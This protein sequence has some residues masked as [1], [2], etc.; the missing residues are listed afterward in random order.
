MGEI[1][2]KEVL[3]LEGKQRD[4]QKKLYSNLPIIVYLLFPIFDVKLERLYHKNYI[5]YELA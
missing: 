1:K 3:E 4:G 2:K 5:Y